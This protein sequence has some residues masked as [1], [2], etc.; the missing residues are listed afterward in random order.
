MKPTVRKD[1]ALGVPLVA[2]VPQQQRMGDSTAVLPAPV[3]GVPTCRAVPRF[4]LG[5]PF[6][7]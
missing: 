1:D 4:R 7:P 6:Y 2:T 5:H 3:V